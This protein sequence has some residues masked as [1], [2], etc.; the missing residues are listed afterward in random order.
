MQR[1]LSISLTGLLIGGCAGPDTIRPPTEP[2]RFVSVGLSSK[3]VREIPAVGLIGI[4][5]D[6]I[7]RLVPALGP[8]GVA[9]GAPL[10]RLRD[11]A[12]V[13][14]ALVDAVQRQLAALQTSVT[15]EIAPDADALAI[16][17]SA[18]RA[19]AEQ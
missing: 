3:D 16:A 7:D 1:V 17:L 11:G 18:L 13:E 2:S 12:R 19:A 10:R 6:A 5:D 9:L 14:A 8:Q 4:L 15:A